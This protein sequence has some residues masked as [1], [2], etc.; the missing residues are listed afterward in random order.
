LLE[1]D[2]DAARGVE[3]IA[4]L[5]PLLAAGEAVDLRGLARRPWMRKVVIATQSC[6]ANFAICAAY[7]L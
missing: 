3:Q 4:A 5:L 2:A 1:D 7:S 6:G